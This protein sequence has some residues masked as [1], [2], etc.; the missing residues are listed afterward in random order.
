MA[1]TTA[2]RADAFRKRQQERLARADRMEV[3]LREI[4]VGL[5]DTKTPKGVRLREI[6][7][8]AVAG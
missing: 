6:A 8:Q 1:L 7:E 3:A 4:I 2:Q 5:A